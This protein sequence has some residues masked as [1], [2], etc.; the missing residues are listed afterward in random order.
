MG[1]TSKCLITNLTRKEKERKKKKSRFVSLTDFPWG[2]YFYSD[3]LQANNVKSVTDGQ[4][5]RDAHDGL[6]SQAEPAP[7][8]C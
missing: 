8:H 2:K 6:P 3:L 1:Y 4:C 5:G 7:A